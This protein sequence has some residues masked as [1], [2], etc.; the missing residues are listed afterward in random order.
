MPPPSRESAAAAAGQPGQ[1]V[2]QLRELDLP[3]ALARPRAPGKNIEDELSAIDHLAID[4]LFD[5]TEL[6][7]GQ[8]VVEN[9]HVHSDA[10]AFGAS[11][12]SLPRP[13]NVAGSGVGRS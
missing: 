2:L 9:H 5:V 3:L 6:G 4:P 13:T 10:R 8:L 11:S 7:G 12:S 1:Q